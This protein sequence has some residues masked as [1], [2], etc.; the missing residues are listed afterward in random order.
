MI[1][2]KLVIVDVTTFQ[3]LFGAVQD[4]ETL[5]FAMSP[6]EAQR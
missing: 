4:Q 5:D 3:N 6:C 2:R 1:F